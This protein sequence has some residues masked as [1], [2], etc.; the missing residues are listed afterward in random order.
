ML[1]PTTAQAKGN[2]R[3]IAAAP[4]LLAA[5]EWVMEE[6]GEVAMT[7]GDRCCLCQGENDDIG[8]LQHTADCPLT[9]ARAAIAKA[10]GQKEAEH[11]PPVS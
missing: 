7:D 4:D 2:T 1:S 5:L 9:V 3:L 11:D 6:L 8:Q 10:R